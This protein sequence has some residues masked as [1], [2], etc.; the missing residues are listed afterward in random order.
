MTIEINHEHVKPACAGFTSLFYAPF[1]GELRKDQ[2]RRVAAAKIICESCPFIE[3]CLT[4]ALE[5]GEKYGVWGGVELSGRAG[6]MVAA[7]S[8]QQ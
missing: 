7:Q 5:N 4:T 1:N 8:N 6:K 2:I 3:Q